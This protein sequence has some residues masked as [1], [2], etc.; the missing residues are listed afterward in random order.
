MLCALLSIGEAMNGEQ[1]HWLLQCRG[2]FLKIIQG[3]KME[4]KKMFW[5]ERTD[6]EVLNSFIMLFKCFNNGVTRC[7]V[8]FIYIIIAITTLKYHQ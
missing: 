3:K 1:F 7:S 6:L 5:S 4:G 8:N 2:I